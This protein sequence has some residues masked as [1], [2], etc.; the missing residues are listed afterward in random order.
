MQFNVLEF[1]V[2]NHC[3]AEL[4]SFVLIK[5]KVFSLVNEAKAYSH[6]LAQQITDNCGFFIGC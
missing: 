6:L 1:Q 3:A 4:N 2:Y 5:V